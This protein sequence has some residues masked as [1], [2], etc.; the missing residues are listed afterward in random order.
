MR[1]LAPFVAC[2]PNGGGGSISRNR[3]TIEGWNALE[4]EPPRSIVDGSLS[5]DP[6][7]DLLAAGQIVADGPISAPSFRC[8][9]KTERD[10]IVYGEDR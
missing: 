2:A 10:A 3:G 9:A 8:T 6:V 4:F 5:V 1:T 7:R